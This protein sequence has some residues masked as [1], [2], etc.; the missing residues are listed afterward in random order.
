MSYTANVVVAIATTLLATASGD[1]FE[2]CGDTY[3]RPYRYDVLF[4]F[5]RSEAVVDFPSYFRWGDPP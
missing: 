1:L 4:R 5:Y 3:A 2:V